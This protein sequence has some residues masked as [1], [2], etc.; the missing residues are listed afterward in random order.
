MWYLSRQTQGVVPVAKDL[1][2]TV[3]RALLG[4]W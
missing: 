1:H 4:V 2:I 3:R